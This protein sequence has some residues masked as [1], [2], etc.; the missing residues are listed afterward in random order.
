MRATKQWVSGAIYALACGGMLTVAAGCGSSSKSSG[1][2][3]DFA[4]LRAKFTSPTGTLGAG[5]VPKVG[6]GLSSQQQSGS[7]PVAGQ[8]YRAGLHI[9]APTPTAPWTCP[10]GGGGT[11]SSSETCTCS[12]GGSVSIAASEQ[13]STTVEGTVDYNGCTYTEAS[14]T[15]SVNGSVSMDI[16][17]GP[18]LLFMYS[19]TI[20]EVVTPPGTHV[21]LNMEFADVGGKITYSVS[22]ASGNVLV[23]SDGTWD[24][25]MKSGTFTVIDKSTT[26]QCSLTNGSGTCTGSNGSTLHVGA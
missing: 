18:P 22:L 23:Q 3:V 1:P 6:D 7:V 11:N 25:A 16:E 19:G 15:I 10:N 20:D 26:W 4:A 9:E 5:D 17:Q 21:H 24:S 14:T 13:T 12:G 2:S 8:A